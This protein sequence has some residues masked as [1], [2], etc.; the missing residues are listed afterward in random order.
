MLSI[1]T[2]WLL[3]EQVVE[4]APSMKQLLILGAGYDTRGF[5]LDLPPPQQQDDKDSSFQV[6]EVDQ[7]DVQIKKIANLKSLSLTD[8][9]VADRME[10]SFVKFVPVDFTVDSLDDKL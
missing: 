9:R 3:D 10:T 1:R 6:W 5:R 4:A 2:K 7:P 8:S